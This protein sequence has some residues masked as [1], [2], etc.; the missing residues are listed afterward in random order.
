MKRILAWLGKPVDMGTLPMWLYIVLMVYMLIAIYG[1]F[2]FL[3][4]W[5]VDL[6]N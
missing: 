2:H 3:L 4:P 5:H 6:P 1:Q